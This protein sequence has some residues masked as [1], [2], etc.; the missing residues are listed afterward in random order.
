MTGNYLAIK[1]PFMSSAARAMDV[2]KWF[3][4]HQQALDLLCGQQLCTS[5]HVLA[6]ILP[7]VTH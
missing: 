2:I 3:N 7:V 1:A 6:L 5:G 4:N